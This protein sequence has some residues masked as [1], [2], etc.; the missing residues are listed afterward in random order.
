MT[1]KVSESI[2]SAHSANELALAEPVS[3][4]YVANLMPREVI[5]VVKVA[6][7]INDFQDTCEEHTRTPSMTTCPERMVGI[8]SPDYHL[9]RHVGTYEADGHG[10]FVR[11]NERH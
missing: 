2:L 7:V 10:R 11:R 5:K 6:K 9:I 3:V 1:L 8:H 4:E